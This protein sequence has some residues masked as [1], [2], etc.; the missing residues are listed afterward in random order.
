MKKFNIDFV[1]N[2]KIYFSI[3]LGIMAIGII[4]NIILGTQLDI[5]FTGGAISKYSYVSNLDE[6]ELKDIVQNATS[7]NV[8]IQ[9]SKNIS[10]SN[11]KN[12]LSVE[13]S[14]GNEISLEQQ[15]NLTDSLLEKFPN[16]SFEQ[17]EVSSVNPSMGRTFFFKC[18]AAIGIASILMVLYV[19]FRFRKIRGLS[20]GMMALV[21]LAHDIIMVYF[22]FIIFR[23]PLDDSFIA[24]I[25]M[26]LGYS[27][28]DTIII[29]DRIRENRDLMNKKTPLNVL[30]NKSMNQTFQ[31]TISTS[32][33]T[34]VAISSVL[35]VALVFNLPSVVSFSL[36]MLVGVLSGC[37][38]SICIACP[39]WV[40]W[41]SKK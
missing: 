7:E 8:S 5:Q 37:Y 15:K 36:P 20:A 18:L 2:K 19:T 38:S 1:G 11:D 39:L 9:I 3:S 10:S 35:I 30:V 13:F 23:M 33:S 31:R 32:V 4:F 6:A 41:E 25:L 29:Y 14:G 24:V 12:I 27:L 28:N 40:L 34:L 26:I 17:I 22:T 16:S 21:A